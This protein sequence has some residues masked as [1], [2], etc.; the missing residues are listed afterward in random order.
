MSLPFVLIAAVTV[1]GAAAALSL[2]NLVHCALCLVVAFGGLALLY[3]GLDAQFVG[4]VQLLVYV[5]AVA[6][7]IVFAILLTERSASTEATVAT[8]SRLGG[9]LVAAL[10]LGGL[11]LAIA[12]SPALWRIGGGAIGGE[13]VSG[14]SVLEVGR[15]LMTDYVVPLEV[16]GVLL[17]SAMIGAVILAIQ[18]RK[19]AR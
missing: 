14:P 5:G 15:S 8:Y 6:V 3:L 12:G 19:G 1:A 17:T 4:W 16:V 9:A 18:E 11:L 7:L 13:A 10:V 2:R